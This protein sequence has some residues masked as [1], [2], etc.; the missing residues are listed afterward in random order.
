[1]VEWVG[2]DTGLEEQDPGLVSEAVAQAGAAVAPVDL[3]PAAARGVA[4]AAVEQVRVGVCGSPAV[5]LARDPG[6]GARARRV[7]VEEPGQGAAQ[8]VEVA[9]APVPVRATVPVVEEVEP[10]RAKE[11]LEGVGGQERLLQ[12]N[13]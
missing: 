1:M 7:R 3:G 11:E 5:R 4:P 2:L 9:V 12:E 10:A 13:G 8:E 6:V